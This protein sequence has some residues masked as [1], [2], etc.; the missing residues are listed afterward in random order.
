MQG[1]AAGGLPAV[2]DLADRAAQPQSAGRS[3]R[4]LV[5]EPAASARSFARKTRCVPLAPSWMTRCSTI[6]PVSAAA[7]LRRSVRA[8]CA[9]Q[10]DAVR[11]PLTHCGVADTDRER[12][13]LTGPRI[14][15]DPGARLTALA[16]APSCSAHLLAPPL[17]RRLVGDRVT[18]LA[19]DERESSAPANRQGGRRDNVVSPCNTTAKGTDRPPAPPPPWT[20]HS[21]SPSLISIRAIAGSAAW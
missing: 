16:H 2:E 20:P 12:L 9:G 21:W 5:D 18:R 7:E 13:A 14:A 11:L 10:P 17:L 1:L 3:F 19:G 15:G 6:Q 8:A 4:H